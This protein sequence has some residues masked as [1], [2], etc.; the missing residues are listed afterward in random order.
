[1]CTL[2]ILFCSSSHFEILFFFF[3]CFLFFFFFV[4]KSSEK[5][6]VLETRTIFIILFNVWDLTLISLFLIRKTYSDHCTLICNAKNTNIRIMTIITIMS[7]DLINQKISFCWS[8]YHYL[9]DCWHDRNTSLWTARHFSA[10]I[11]Q[12][13]QKIVK[14]MQNLSPSLIL[15]KYM[16]I[17]MLLLQLASRD[18]L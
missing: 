13:L 5:L 6:Y 18:Q 10:Q 3:L 2:W 14:Q 11:W 7:L 1:M 8:A 17:I 16:Y 15:V 12:T 4:T 9:V